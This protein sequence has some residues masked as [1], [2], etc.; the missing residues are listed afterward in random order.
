[1]AGGI[2]V[3]FPPL[4]AVGFHVMRLAELRAL[5]VDRFPLSKNRGGLMT[6]VEAVCTSLS[7]ALIPAEVWVDGSF[8]T[9]KIDPADVD[10]AVRVHAGALPN[11][12]PEQLGILDRVTQKKFANCDS[13][14]FAE[15]PV[16]HAQHAVGD[17]MHAYWQRQWGFT[18][19]DKFKGIAVVRTPLA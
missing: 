13:Y 3:D 17:M 4:L 19:A 11:P 14:V 16:G 2:K 1:M 8:L 15:Y 18:R 12:G 5:C 7:T 10:L 9:E 6:A